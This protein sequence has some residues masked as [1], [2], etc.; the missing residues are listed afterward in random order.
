MGNGGRE[1]IMERRKARAE[2]EEIGRR[3]EK[4]TTEQCPSNVLH[5]LNNH[6]KIH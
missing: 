4:T 5:V 1:E 6:L 3:T 2:E